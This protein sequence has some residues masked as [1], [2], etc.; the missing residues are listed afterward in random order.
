MREHETTRELDFSYPADGK[1]NSFVPNSSILAKTIDSIEMNSSL[2]RCNISSSILP[3]LSLIQS[4]LIQHMGRS[5]GVI[6]VVFVCCEEK[7]RERSQDTRDKTLHHR[8]DKRG[9]TW[10]TCFWV[11]ACCFWCCCWLRCACSEVLSSLILMSVFSWQPRNF[12]MH[13]RRAAQFWKNI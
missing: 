10:G 1:K 6:N 9:R 8:R 3:D 11:H 12:L 2:T 5:E 13:C 4:L 7:Q